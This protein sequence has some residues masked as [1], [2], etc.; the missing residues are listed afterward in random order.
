MALDSAA[1]SLPC[2]RVALERGA[3]ARRRRTYFSESFL[4]EYSRLFMNA[5]PPDNSAP[6]HPSPPKAPPRKT[7]WQRRGVHFLL[8]A[9]LASALAMLFQPSMAGYD[10]AIID[11]YFRARGAAKSKDVAKKFPNTRDIIMVET[12]HPIP[13]EVQAKLVRA[14]RLARVVAFDFMFPEDFSDLTPEE[15]AMPEYVRAR[16]ENARQNAA[17]ARAMHGAGNVVIGMWPEERDAL[18]QFENGAE[19]RTAQLPADFRG[20]T[21]QGALSRVLATSSQ[22]VRWEK[23]APLL[24]NAARWHSHVRADPDGDGIVRAV[25]PFAMQN[26]ERVPCL[27][28]ALAGAARGLT[29]AQIAALPQNQNGFLFDGKR[30][31]L[32]DDGKMRVDFVGDRSAFQSLENR[33]V[34]TR[35]LDGTYLPEDFK[36]KIVIIGE[37]SK[38]SKEIIATPFGTMPGMQIHANVV[39]TLLS[40]TGPPHAL[41][42][43]MVL[44]LCVCCALLLVAPLLRFPLWS[45]FVTAALQ[46]VALALAGLWLFSQTNRILAPSAAFLTI[47]LT[48][49]ALSLYEYRRARQ[50]LGRFIGQDMLP[51]AMQLFSP[52]QLGGRVEIATA[53]FCDL[54]GYSGVSESLAPDQVTA[55]INEYSSEMVTVVHRFGGRTIDYLGDGIFFLFEKNK[56]GD[57]ALRA[58]R[59]ALEMQKSFELLATR[60]QIEDALPAKPEMG[61]GIA[62]GEMMIGAVGSEERIKLS[63]IGD[64]VN[65]ASRAQG[66]TQSCG[67][68][69]LITLSTCDA[70]RD[71]VEARSCGLHILRGR[72]TPIELFG[73]LGVS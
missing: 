51:R 45:S 40:E 58:V 26:G 46:V 71:F 7:L 6:D 57:H 41:P 44:A 1:P 28:L 53:L 21:G 10:D 17:L 65:V 43:W 13:R 8:I 54:R 55:Y 50:T 12:S 11:S 2:R 36:D 59:A 62:T 56:S 72:K 39:A 29:R 68:N 3:H 4:R 9:L 14:L 16:R 49:N 63:A 33:I 5:L 47:F 32:R 18:S 64:A 70:V 15:K 30:I 38:S 37:S 22:D 35:V 20:Q 60:R 34:Y 25:T 52:L 69:I 42:H 27:G 61:I 31:A 48:L 23:P 24:W 73:V 67:Y 19:Q 66:L